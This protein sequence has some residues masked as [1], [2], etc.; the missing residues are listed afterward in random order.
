MFA[1]G[2]S[3]AVTIRVGIYKAQNDWENINQAGLTAIKLVILVM[4]F[5]CL[6]FL[7]L[8]NILPL[9]FSNNAEII[10]LSSKLLVIAAMFQMFDGLQVTVI[11]ILRG[12]EDAKVPT[13]ITLVGYWLIALPLS[14][15]LAFKMKWE[16][17]GVWIALLTSLA[18][19][20]VSVYWRFKYLVNKNS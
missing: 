9:G 17:V 1:S 4:A 15:F 13:V 12:L 16:V 7:S 8:R 19:V 6:V 11:G 2:I 10:S 18:L 5:F 3:S 14:Y 20:A